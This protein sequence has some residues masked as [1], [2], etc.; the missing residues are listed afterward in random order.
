M[1]LTPGPS[2]TDVWQ[3]IF[4]GGTFV[5][6]FGASIIGLSQFRDYR[7][8]AREQS[9]P[10][11]LVDIAVRE[12]LLMLGVRNVG[13]RPAANIV[14]RFDPEIHSTVDGWAQTIRAAFDPE[15]PLPVL[16]PGRSLQWYLDN[17]L[18][19]VNS[20]TVPQDYTVG[21][22]YEDL[23]PRML[24]AHRVWPWRRCSSHGGCV[25]GVS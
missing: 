10:Y 1:T 20:G 14:V 5:V 13:V 7:T 21:I 17:G 18:F 12:T 2:V 6:A 23:E 19:A 11:V 4:A 8:T 15:K 16:A 24:W 9:R 22:S 3:A 25:R